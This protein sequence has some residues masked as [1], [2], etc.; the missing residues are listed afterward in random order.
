MACLITNALYVYPYREGVFFQ[1]VVSHIDV[2][3][4]EKGQGV[5]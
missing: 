4:H 5:P 1:K 2:S 3:Q